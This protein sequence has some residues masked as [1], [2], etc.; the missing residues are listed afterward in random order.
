MTSADTI[1]TRITE[2]P[3]KADALAVLSG[4]SRQALEAV[5][6]QLYVDT[7]GK[8]VARVRSECVSEARA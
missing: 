7:F 2:A 8:T 6:D 4:I 3:T 1:I 5:A